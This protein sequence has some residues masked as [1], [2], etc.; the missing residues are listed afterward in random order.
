M[1]DRG[2]TIRALA[3]AGGL[4]LLAGCSKGG[5]VEDFTPPADNARKALEAALNHWKA[6]H[7]PGTVPGTA[8]AV[9]ATDSKWRAG[10]KLADYE[11]LG[12]DPAGPGPRTFK[13]RLTPAKGPPQEV[14]YMVLGIDPLLVYREDDFKKL[15]GTGM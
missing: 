4:A 9:E 3:L 13:V 10:Q 1:T 11:V 15:S 6:G 12:E 7:S 5:R 14:R 2:R 8:P